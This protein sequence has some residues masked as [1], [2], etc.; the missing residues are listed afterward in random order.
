LE[1][2]SRGNGRRLGVVG[3]KSCLRSRSAARPSQLF[4]TR[5]WRP[6][7]G[8]SGVRH[9]FSRTERSGPRLMRML[10][11]L[12]M[13]EE[14]RR[15]FDPPAA[16]HELVPARTNSC[17]RAGE[18]RRT[19]LPASVVSRAG[20]EEKCTRCTIFVDG[21]RHALR[22]DWH[23]RSGSSALRTDNCAQSAFAPNDGFE[24]DRVRETA[25]TGQEWRR[26]TA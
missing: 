10:R 1:S 16:D 8:H 12:R 9:T 19:W 24:A 5:P 6:R 15:T 2:G 11:A 22:C 17:G 23:T 21:L 13:W 25:C 7:R 26:K 14:R 18:V 3:F 20:R 4:V